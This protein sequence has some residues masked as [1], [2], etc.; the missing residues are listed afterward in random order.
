MS[1]RPLLMLSVGLAGSLALAACSSPVFPLRPGDA[2][3]ADSGTI[4]PGEDVPALPDDDTPVTPGDDVP[5]LLTDSGL[6]SL[7]NSGVMSAAMTL[8]PTQGSMLRAFDALYATA[9][10]RKK[11]TER[12]M[13][14]MKIQP[15]DSGSLISRKSM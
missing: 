15:A 7:T 12:Q 13:V 11:N 9:S 4:L 14:L 3:E 6:D 10:G 2:G 8:N 5:V 1:T